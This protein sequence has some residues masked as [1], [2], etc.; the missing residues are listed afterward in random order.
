MTASTITR[1]RR[2]L[3]R[4]DP[5]PGRD[6]NALIG[7]SKA[8]PYLFSLPAIDVL[9]LLCEGFLVVLGLLAVGHGVRSL[10]RP[11]KV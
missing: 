1:P 11:G 3:R 8:T 4:P 2:W 7:Q 6:N 5:G 9:G 10:L